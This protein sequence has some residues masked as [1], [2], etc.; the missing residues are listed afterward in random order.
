[1]LNPGA[2]ASFSICKS[3]TSII[4]HIL[5]GLAL[6]LYGVEKLS[7]VL[8][9]RLGPR[10]EKWMHKAAMNRPAALVT[11][12]VVTVLLDSSSAVI[13]MTIVMVNSG[14][15]NLRQAMAI[16]LGANVGTTAGSQIIALDVARFSPLLLMVGM[17]MRWVKKKPGLQGTGEI[18]FYAGLL[19]FGLFTMEYAV[20]PLKSKPFFM[21]WLEKTHDPLTGSFS[22][23]I[24]T[25]IIQS[26]S[27]VVGMAIVLAKKGLLTLKGGV[28]VMM[29]TELG[30]CSDTLLATI[31]GRRDAIK[32]ALFHLSV[33]LIS[34]VAGLMFFDAFMDLVQWISQE[35]PPERALANAHMLFN[36]LGTAAFYGL[37]PFFESLLN[38]LLPARTGP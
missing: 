10:A 34:V 33:N 19:F 24:A 18:L 2:K 16:V 31:N 20:E 23:A 36:V 37:I 22:G 17:M 30:T 15:L 27:A 14:L 4:L 32:T 13:I 6:F 35:A 5:G 8:H 11:G 9:Q 28:A 3:V 29:G 7:A 21:E 25:L 26:S 1:M 12:F 38:K